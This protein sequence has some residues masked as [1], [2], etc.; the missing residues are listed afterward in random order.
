MNA[1]SANTV[2]SSRTPADDSAGME[3]R[4]P[5]GL[6]GEGAAL[7]DIADFERV[8]ILK[9]RKTGISAVIAVHS[10]IL[11]PA[12]GGCRRWRYGSSDAGLTDALRL[13][14]GMTYKNALAGIPFGGGKSV[15]FA[16]ER[17]KP[18]AAQLQVFAGW[19]NEL[20]G[21]YVTA[22]DVGMGV[23]QMQTLARH[24]AF[25]SG[26]GRNGVG[27]DPSPKTAYGV[28]LGLKRAAQ[29]H[30]DREHLYGLR[31]AVQGLGSVGLS[32]CHWLARAGAELVV[33]DM[34]PSRVQMAVR[35]YD[36]TAVEVDDITRVDADVFAPCALGGVIDEAFARRTSVR[37]VAGAANNQL[38][39][40]DCADMLASRNIA[41][42]PD[43]VINAG[44]V[45]SVAH[46][47]LLER[48]YFSGAGQHDC[49][50]WVG[51][52]IA[53][54]GDRVRGILEESR[55]S[56]LN[57]DRVARRMAQERLAAPRSCAA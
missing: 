50:A 19:V 57:T 42:V 40:A 6:S 49:E 11:G 36:A 5:R 14:E 10:T 21:S 23:A 26:L 3:P 37:I 20:A 56:G 52:R 1:H 22:E 38:L 25:V 48:G 17:E 9:D 39:T 12:A 53:A 34:D 18:S 16:D 31:V 47:Y 4:N 45:I 55:T 30:L 43:F 41:Y 44:G 13:A 7:P 8:E 46:E 2:N 35:K 51:S 29:I 28:F 27:G 15:I 32:L 54:I 33:A 24:S